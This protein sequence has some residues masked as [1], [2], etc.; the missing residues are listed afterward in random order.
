MVVVE[1]AERGVAMAAISS[2]ILVA[3]ARIGPRRV[4][5]YGASMGGMCAREFLLRYASAGAPWGRPVLV[6]GQRAEFGPADAAP[7]VGLLVRV[8]VPAADPLATAAVALVSAVRAGPPVEP[9]ADRAV[10]AGARRAAALGSG[11]PALASQAAFIAAF[12]PLRAGEFEPVLARAGYPART[13]TR[14]GIRWSTPKPR[15]RTG[16][17][18]FRP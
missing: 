2:S 18:P 7:A 9:A 1:Y 11:Q 14:P 16:N 12:P 3:L 15:Y 5:V 8:L 13:W 10:I 6:L 17:G 4:V